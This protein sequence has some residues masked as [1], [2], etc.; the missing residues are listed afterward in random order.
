MPGMDGLA[1]CRAL[2]HDAA[3][4]DVPVL[5]VSGE[6]PSQLRAALEAGCD[7]VLTKPC[8]GARLVSMVEHLLARGRE[9]QSDVPRELPESAVPAGAP[10]STDDTPGTRREPEANMESEGQPLQPADDE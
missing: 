8:T 7:A 5:V 1:L 2:R 10:R 4:R 6:D 9:R 3:T